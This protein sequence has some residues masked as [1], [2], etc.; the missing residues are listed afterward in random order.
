MSNLAV[1][2]LLVA[3]ALVAWAGIGLVVTQV[4]PDTT[5]SQVLFFGLMY[6]AWASSLTI[7]AYYLS[8]RLFASRAY[9]G[10]LGR[11]LQQGLLWAAFVLVALVMQLARALSLMTGVVLLALFGLAAAVVLSRR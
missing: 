6:T 10:N 1:L 9:R 3:L 8:F 4:S 2:R 11:S 5:L 7:V